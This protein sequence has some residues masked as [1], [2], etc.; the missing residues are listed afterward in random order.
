MVDFIEV[1]L[2]PILREDLDIDSVQWLAD[3]C[4]VYNELKKVANQNIPVRGCDY[5][6]FHTVEQCGVAQHES[7]DCL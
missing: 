5:N 3:I 7:P 4:H 6:E 2:I 1:N